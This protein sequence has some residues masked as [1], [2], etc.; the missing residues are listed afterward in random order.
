VRAVGQEVVYALTDR[1]DALLTPE[2]VETWY[3]AFERVRRGEGPDLTEEELAVDAKVEVDPEASAL[4]QKL[5]RLEW[6]V[7]YLAGAKS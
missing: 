3:I 6:A 2:E 5:V 1:L 7:Y 4:F